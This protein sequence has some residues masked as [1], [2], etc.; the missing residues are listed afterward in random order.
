MENN[1]LDNSEK[2]LLLG[3]VH[4][5]LAIF[6]IIAKI[7]PFDVLESLQLTE[8]TYAILLFDSIIMGSILY[9]LSSPLQKNPQQD[10]S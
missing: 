2:I 1:A 6:L 3:I 9:A 4:Y 7:V 5:V 8:Q 10:S